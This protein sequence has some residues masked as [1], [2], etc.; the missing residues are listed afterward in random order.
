MI[1]RHSLRCPSGHHRPSPQTT[2]LSSSTLP[3][4]PI[5][6]SPPS[7]SLL[8]LSPPNS[9]PARRLVASRS[10]GSTCSPPLTPPPPPPPSYA[11]PTCLPS[12]QHHAKLPATPGGSS[13]H[14]SLPALLHPNLCLQSSEAASQLQQ[15]SLLPPPDTLCI[16]HSPHSSPP[17][18][19][20]HSGGHFSHAS[21]LTRGDGI[22]PNNVHRQLPGVPRH[23]HHHHHHHAT[24]VRVLPSAPRTTLPTPSP[25]HNSS[26]SPHPPSSPCLAG[27]PTYALLSANYKYS[28]DVPRVALR[29]LRSNT[30]PPPGV[31]GST[32]SSSSDSSSNSSAASSSSTTEGPSPVADD[33]S[34]QSDEEYDPLLP[35]SLILSVPVSP[36]LCPPS[37][38]NHHRSSCA[39]SPIPCVSPIPILSPVP[40]RSPIPPRSPLPIRSPV[41]PSKS[42]V[43]PWSPVPPRSPTPLRS[44]VPP[45]SPITI[46]SPVPPRSPLPIH[47]PVPMWSSQSCW[48]Q[49]PLKSPVTS[50]TP[51]QQSVSLGGGPW[52]VPHMGCAPRS[53]NT[54]PCPGRSGTRLHHTSSNPVVGSSASRGVAMCAEVSSPLHRKST[55]P[56]LQRSHATAG[57]ITRSRSVRA[58]REEEW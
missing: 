4:S 33:F 3:P 57:W 58:C 40:Q 56:P 25:P 2:T 11:I 41:P 34:S 51:L 22:S 42:P 47:S 19:R 30:Y 39:S 35:S 26:C 18:S 13:S 53:L 38:S 55:R 1:R 43:P 21:A 27:R 15:N 5:H 9:A 10:L 20:P 46:R 8:T 37:P 32:S 28:L 16:V 36:R 45:R 14:R 44:P 50:I 7:P 6:H 54:S 49:V 48:S 23:Q 17:S 52:T 24:G 12:H 29:D 31:E